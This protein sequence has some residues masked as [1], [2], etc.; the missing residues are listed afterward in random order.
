MKAVKPPR[1]IWSGDWWEE[2]DRARQEAEERA[3]PL[4]E[5]ARRRAEA[6][7]PP[8]PPQ[9]RRFTRRHKILAGALVATTVTLSAFAIGTLVGGGPATSPDPLPA[10]SDKPLKPRQ[11]QTR[12]G[13][14]Y[15][16]AS[17]AVV[18]IRTSSGSGTGFLIDGTGRI[19]TNSHVVGQSKSV[20]VRFG[21]DQTSL[22]GKVV[23]SDPSSDL[24]I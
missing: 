24:A 1:H 18:S 19:V 6:D 3:P 16:H 22:D 21:D 5:E 9:P 13:A 12:A 4:G 7:R 14:I 11:R 8:A 23:G 10:V 17:P 2:S 15:A 20:L